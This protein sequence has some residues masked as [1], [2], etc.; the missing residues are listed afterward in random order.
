[1]AIASAQ[2]G[3]NILRL[4]FKERRCPCCAQPFASGS[5]FCSSCMAAMPRRSGGFCPVCGELY[6]GGPSLPNDICPACL[7]RRPPWGK[8]YFHAA[9]S[10]LLRDLVLGLK[11]GGH[12][13]LARGLAAMLS[14]HPDLCDA[15]SAYDF[16]VPTPLHCARFA[17]RGFN[18]AGEIARFLGKALDLPICFALERKIATRHQVGLSRRERVKNLRGA[19][20]VVFNVRGCKILLLDDVM[21]TG[22]T[23]ASATRSLLEAGAALVDVIAPARTPARNML[24]ESRNL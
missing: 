24:R 8:A 2:S 23:F 3:R 5:V 19:F 4:L 1:M 13:H 11:F 6:A 14:G 12:L 10:G 20:D 16:I 9:Y 22:A 15:K 17:E 7:E 21:T 18:Q